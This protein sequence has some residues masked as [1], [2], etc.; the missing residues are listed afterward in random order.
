MSVFRNFRFKIVK[1]L[2]KGKDAKPARFSEVAYLKQ[3]DD[4]NKS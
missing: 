1:L 3:D 2:I 4:I